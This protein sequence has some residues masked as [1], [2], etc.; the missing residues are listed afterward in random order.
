MQRVF[1]TGTPWVF[2]PE[3]VAVKAVLVERKLGAGTPRIFPCIQVTLSRAVAV[4]GLQFAGAARVLAS[5]GVAV[6]GAV[7]MG[8]KV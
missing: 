1:I 4:E 5:E 8:G 6:R 3:P 2:T 7:W